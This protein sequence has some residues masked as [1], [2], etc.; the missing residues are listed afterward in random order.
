MYYTDK[1]V[2]T[3]AISQVLPLVLYSLTL[4]Y[5]MFQSLMMKMIAQCHPTCQYKVSGGQR[6]SRRKTRK[7]E[8]RMAANSSNP[9]INIRDITLRAAF[10]LCIQTNG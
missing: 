4:K 6:H 10:P 9:C 2:I 7:D 1:A 8:A 3:Q 5:I